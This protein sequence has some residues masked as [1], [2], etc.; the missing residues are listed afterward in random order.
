M[1]II[2]H[3]IFNINSP[4]TASYI[5]VSWQVL[6]LKRSPNLSSS[7]IHFRRK[8]QNNNRRGHSGYCW[9]EWWIQLYKMDNWWWFS[10]CLQPIWLDLVL[11][12]NSPLA[13]IG[14]SGL[15]GDLL[16][17][18]PSSHIASSSWPTS[19]PAE[20]VSWV[21]ARPTC[22]LLTPSSC[23]CSWPAAAPSINCCCCCC[24][25]SLTGGGGSPTCCANLL[26]QCLQHR[27]Q[28]AFK[29]VVS[30]VSELQ[31]R[32]RLHRPTGQSDFSYRLALPGVQV[33]RSGIQSSGCR[34]RRNLASRG[35]FP[36][37]LSCCSPA[38]PTAAWD[39]S[40]L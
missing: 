33:P 4:K 1:I 19:P 37:S 38:L 8:N 20:N 27:D 22:R 15:V 30:R 9:S 17:G 13:C 3:S 39:T 14:L 21:Q 34:P 6:L 18:G 36:A 11:L 23:Q 24:C 16:E 7:G 12:L 35:R 25:C 10:R 29:Y 2:I 31:S 32:H 40:V 5:P 28:L 26:L